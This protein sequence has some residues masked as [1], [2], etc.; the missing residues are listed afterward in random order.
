MN[1]GRSLVL[2]FPSL[3]L[4]PNPHQGPIHPIY[5]I[6]LWHAHSP[7]LLLQVLN[8][9][10]APAVQIAPLGCGLSNVSSLLTYF[11]VCTY[12]RINTNVPVSAF[13]RQAAM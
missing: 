2:T 1:S 12:L 8:L 13:A 7:N 11:D 5:R 6:L 3:N 9:F 10:F 4:S